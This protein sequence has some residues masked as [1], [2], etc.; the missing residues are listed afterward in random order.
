MAPACRSC[1]ALRRSGW[2]NAGAVRGKQRAHG[3]SKHAALAGELLG[4]YPVG[5]TEAI[6]AAV[7]A[8]AAPADLGR[9]LAYGAAL[10]WLAS[11][12][13]MSTPTGSR[14]TTSSPTPTLSARCSGKSGPRPLITSRRRGCPARCDG[15]LSHAL[16]QCAASPHS[17]RGGRPARRPARRRGDAPAALLD[18][19]D[20]QRQ[21]DLAARLVA[22]HFRRGHS[23]QALIATLAHA[24][25]REDAGFHAYQMLEAESGN[26]RC[27]ATV[28]RAGTSSLRSLAISPPIR[29]PNARR[30]RRRTSP[31]A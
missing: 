12:T 2:P 20:R 29:R 23:P 14:R 30:C 19:F 1:R 7:C 16:S 31:A 10:R 27:G 25:L 11:A 22:R 26:S 13:P 24:V 6:K 15:P 9:A 28:M 4:D 8:G 18:A 3:W 5:I 21:V 17:W